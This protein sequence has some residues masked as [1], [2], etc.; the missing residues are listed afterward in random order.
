MRIPLK[1]NVA[2]AAQRRHGIGW[3]RP[4]DHLSRRSP[5][6]PNIT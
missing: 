1:K 3:R 4:R 6:N 5:E 2:A